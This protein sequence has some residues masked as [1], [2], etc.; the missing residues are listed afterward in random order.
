MEDTIQKPE[1]ITP[2]SIFKHMLK[3]IN[4]R[5]GD[6]IKGQNEAISRKEVNAFIDKLANETQ[7]LDLPE[8]GPNPQGCD[9]F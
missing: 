8:T 7:L 6:H 3:A 2:E 1:S 5:Y 9:G 4:D